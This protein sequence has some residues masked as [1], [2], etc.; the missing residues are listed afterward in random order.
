MFIQVHKRSVYKKKR[1]REKKT[2]MAIKIIM[3]D[4][5]VVVLYLNTSSD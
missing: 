4:V 5:V 2:N 3:F 1:E